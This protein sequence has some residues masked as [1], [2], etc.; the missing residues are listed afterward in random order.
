MKL[1]LGKDPDKNNLLEASGSSARSK[2][3]IVIDVAPRPDP[4]LPIRAIKK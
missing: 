3:P 1:L 2:R 4:T